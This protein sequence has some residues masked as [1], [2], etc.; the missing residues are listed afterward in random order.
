MRGKAHLS[1]SGSN[2]IIKTRYEHSRL[3]IPKFVK[4]LRTLGEAGT[5]KNGKDGVCVYVNVTN[6]SWFL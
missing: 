1:E 3:E 2:G 4:Y 6:V 5:V